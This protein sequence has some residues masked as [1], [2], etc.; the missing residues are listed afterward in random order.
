MLENPLFQLFLAGF[1]EKTPGFG[2]FRYIFTLK[3]NCVTLNTHLAN[4]QIS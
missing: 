4:M 3:M 1:Y 2:D